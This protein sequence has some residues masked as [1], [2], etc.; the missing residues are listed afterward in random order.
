MESG[1][2]EWRKW[3]LQDQP[4]VRLASGDINTSDA[5]SGA[6]ILP[7]PAGVGD[8]GALTKGSVG[9]GEREAGSP[10]LPPRPTAPF[11]GTAEPDDRKNKE[12]GCSFLN[13]LMSGSH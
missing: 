11:P 4:C 12:L 7:L 9:A 3:L 6:T 5:A 1:R 2:E 13:A 8:K 10:P